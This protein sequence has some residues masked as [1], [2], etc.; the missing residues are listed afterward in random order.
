PEE[1][2]RLASA[3]ARALATA[4][5]GGIIHRDIKPANVL[6]GERGEIKLADFGV[7]HV[8]GA[9]LTIP[10][11]RV[12]TPAYMAPEQLRGKQ[13][14][15]RADV[16]SAGV[17]LFEAAIG[18]RPSDDRDADH[19]GQLLAAT[20]NGVL[21]G[22]ISRAIRDRPADR[23][24]DGAA[25]VA[26]LEATE[27]PSSPPTAQVE[28][29]SPRRRWPW[30]VLAIVLLGAGGSAAVSRYMAH[31]KAAPAV[32]THHTIALLPFADKTGNPMLD[33]ASA[34]L[35]NL[36]GLELHGA[37]DVTVIGYYELLGVAGKDAPHD[38]WVAA[39]KRLGADL[40]VEGE[41][42][43]GGQ[44][45]HITIDINTLA[46]THVDRIERDE[47]VENVPESV[48]RTARM[49]AKLAVGRDVSVGGSSP[50]TFDAD[51]ELQLGI[52]ELDREHLDEANQHLRA[53]IHQDPQNALAHYYLA[54]ALTWMVPP[55]DPAL[56]EIRAALATGKLDDAQRG[57]LA[58]ASK[59]AVFDH[60]GCVDVMR[61]LSEKYP[62]NRDVLY[63]LFECLFHSGRPAEA[64]GVY[65]RIN[66]IA[67]KFRL[68]LVHA[69]T[70]YVSHF[71]E[72]GIEW[73]L[74]LAEPTGD[75]YN[76]AYEPQVLL[77][78]REYQQEIELLSRRLAGADAGLARSLQE[79]L[80][81]VYIITGKLDL[82][83][84]VMKRMAETG[85]DDV[86]GHLGIASAR[87]D[88]VQRRQY[89]DALIRGFSTQ[90]AGAGRALSVAMLIGAQLPVATR[91][92]L[93]TLDKALTAAIVPT[94]EGS[95]NLQ[96]GQVMLA[97]GLEDTVRLAEL[98]RSPYP[99]VSEL[100]HA[101]VA[102]RAG[103]H[104]TAITSL[105]RS[106]AASG[107]ARF[108]VTQWWQLARELVATSDHAGVLAACD[109]VIRPR[110]V[111]TWAWGS[112]VGDC[113]RWTA[114][115]HE[116]NGSIA[117][118]RAAWERLLALRSRAP[119]GDP[120][121]GAAKSAL[122]RLP[123]R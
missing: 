99:E 6:L 86:N 105:R 116:A 87:G 73:A 52:A 90:P 34:G 115:S 7:A 57:L 29:Y 9:E 19:Y 17:T 74:S 122:A 14:D 1:V 69:F 27:A 37:P 123:Q 118:A 110:L 32:A 31:R 98:A 24:P 91:A 70:F 59:M 8:G 18:E 80:F 104:A 23:F 112:T 39:A 77:A 55:A 107:D 44:N 92:D 45:V 76:A 26:A 75:A 66:A 119:A 53:A 46:G 84:A 49:L 108:L 42:T 81:T 103:D 58:G 41:L 109:E 16:Y 20:G 36:L 54:M 28:R 72:R 79:Q 78:R 22:A 67:P 13:V 88:E 89:L 56:E 62:N 111:L 95:L 114:E 96:L 43:G 48:R 61:P 35:P 94:F 38:A 102:R 3:I 64:M 68:A 60:V 106:I 21:A 101:A 30:L 82:A 4:H 83:E 12:G 50:H 10:G 40:L 97:D 100:A 63:V 65:R 2:R 71:D 113:L 93:E 51:R 33:F 5:A 117:A 15:A 121:V 25:F 120:L 47:R 11:S 85:P